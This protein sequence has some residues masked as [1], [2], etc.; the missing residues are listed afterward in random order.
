MSML[1]IGY[2]HIVLKTTAKKECFLLF[3]NIKCNN[4]SINL[5]VPALGVLF[6]TYYF[7]ENEI[8]KHLSIFFFFLE[9]RNVHYYFFSANPRSCIFLAR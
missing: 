9:T 1:F 6:L 2:V 3:Q 4:Y 5:S 7:S 8:K